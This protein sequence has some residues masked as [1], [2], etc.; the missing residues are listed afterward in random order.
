MEHCSPIRGLLL[1]L[2]LAAGSTSVAQA[3][4]VDSLIARHIE[5]RGGMEQL[6]AIETLRMSGRAVA[7]PGQEALVTLEVRPPS[8]IRTE[9]AFQGVTAVYACAD[10]TCWSVSPM[11]GSFEALPMSESDASQEME[12]ANILG[13]LV[14]WKAKGHIVE[15]M[16]TE[17]VDGRA[18]HKLKVT[19]S[20]GVVQTHY[21]DVESALLVRRETTRTF[22]DRP[23]EL[24]TTF[25]DFRPVGGVVFPHL[26]RSSA[27]GRPGSLEVVVEE[28]EL[29]GP[30]DDS[31]FE[32]PG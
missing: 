2:A 27:K 7:G 5:A 6:E 11:A 1:G 12:Q 22:G 24:Q 15:L 3:Q 31:R 16:G 18:A 13:P 32:M 26:I 9:F 25:S 21:L 20:S 8:R 19:L 30:I 17:P 4:N 10:V 28:A 29:N 23:I 14:D